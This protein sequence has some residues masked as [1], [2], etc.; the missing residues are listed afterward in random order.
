MISSTVFVAAIIGMFVVSEC[1]AY[2]DLRKEFIR[3]FFYIS[4]FPVLMVGGAIARM[5]GFE[6]EQGMALVMPMAIVALAY[7]AAIGYLVGCGIHRLLL[8]ASKKSP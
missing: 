2:D 3:R 8:G 4:A 6:G 5:L 1:L 7:Y